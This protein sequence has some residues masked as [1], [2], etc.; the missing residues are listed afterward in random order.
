MAMSVSIYGG[1]WR[2]RVEQGH[3][4]C[5]RLTR[6]TAPGVRLRCS[7]SGAYGWKGERFCSQ[8]HPDWDGWYAEM[9]RLEKIAQAAIDRDP[10]VRP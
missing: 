3:G 1:G 8:H 6:L 4:R 9:R 5:D 2:V 7:R 10:A